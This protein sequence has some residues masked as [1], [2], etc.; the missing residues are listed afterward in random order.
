MADY[1]TVANAADIEPGGMIVVEFND[2]DVAIANVDGELFAFD[3]ECPHAGGP[4]DEGD[5]EGKIVICPWHGAEFDMATGEALT[6]PAMEAVT[7]F[8]VRVQGQDI[9]IAPD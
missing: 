4:L 8:K 6:L 2:L 3:A 9:Q 7:T 1:V 5:V